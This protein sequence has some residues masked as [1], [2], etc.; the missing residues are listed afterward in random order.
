MELTP[1]QNEVLYNIKN[2]LI[3]KNPR[4]IVISG[5]AGTGKTTLAIELRKQ[6]F[7]F[8]DIAFVSYTGKAASVLK[9][10]IGDNL[11]VGDFVGT[12]HSLMYRP[13]KEFDG[14]KWVLVD[15]EKVQ[16]V[17]FDLIIV[18]EAS[19]VD[20][21][22]IKDLE[23]YMIPIVYFGDPFQLPPVS[24]EDQWI[25]NNPDLKL[26]DIMR[27]A[28]ENPVINLANNIRKYGKIEPGL[29][30]NEV[31]KVPWNDQR[32]RD[33]FYSIEFDKSTIVLCGFNKT[34]SN[35][36][37]G[38]RKK[39]GFDYVLC[40]NDRVVCLA[41]NNEA[42]LMNGQLATV[43]WSIPEKNNKYLRL[44]LDVDSI[45]FYTTIVPSWIIG[46][47]DSNT[48]VKDELYNRKKHKELTKGRN[49]TFD[50]VDYGYA[51]TVHKS[52]GSEWNRVILF[53]E[54]LPFFSDHFYARWLYTAVTRSSRK[55]FVI[56]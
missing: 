21:K 40:P 29:Y 46:K 9:E 53:E 22:L 26:T 41:N 27:T 39:K 28:L 1:Q 3:L 30:S 36:N 6:L 24:S 7:E 49:I 33:L 38:I 25:L 2:E 16:D 45:G 20:P 43:V 14:V 34:R 4:R 12:I 31:F 42:G 10:K 44:T 15:W 37:G 32:T 35:I 19:M 48:L 8:R 56:Y 5:Y 52:Q 47:K 11:R 51:L 23:S 50:F 18:D 17:P 13:V 55:L 54:K